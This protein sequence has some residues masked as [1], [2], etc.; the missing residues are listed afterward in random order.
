MT[1]RA[2]A[3]TRCLEPGSFV[4]RR[5]ERIARGFQRFLLVVSVAVAVN[6][7]VGERGI[8][9]MRRSG[10]AQ[11]ALAASLDTLRQ[12]NAQLAEEARRLRQDPA[13]IEQIARRELGLVRRG[14]VVVI[15]RQPQARP[16]A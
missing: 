4:P 1:R 10:R 3:P 2:S 15:L 8:L 9:E 7:L 11:Q 16:P 5:G 14:E 6:A 12:E 13:A